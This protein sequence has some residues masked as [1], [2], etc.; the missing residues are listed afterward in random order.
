MAEKIRFF[1]LE[2]TYKIIDGKAVIHLYGK[3]IKNEQLCVLDE[4]F[5]PYFYVIPKMGKEVQEKLEKIKVE[6]ENE[7]AA[8]TKTEIAKRK[9]LGKEVDAVKVYTKLPKDVPIIREI[10]KDWN[11]LESVN[12]YDIQFRRRYLIDKG[13]TPLTLVEVEGD[14]VTQKSKVPVLKATS[15]KQ[16]SDDALENPRILAFDIE[17][18]SPLGKAIAPE[19]NPI[20]MISFYGEKFEKVFLWKKFKT[21]LKYVEFVDGEE[22]L[23]EKFKETIEHYR[24]D[25]L[26]G[27]FS[28]EFDMP[29]IKTRAERYKIKIDIGL[30]HSELKVKH[31][32]TT[33]SSITGLTHLDI[34]KFIV[35]TM[36]GSFDTEAYSLNNTAK[37]LLNEK[38]LDV[39]LDG[40]SV[41]WDKTPAQLG[42]F[43]EYNLHDSV[44]TYKLC[45]KL[46]PNIME[47]VKI[48]GLPIYD[49]NRMGFSQLVESYLLKQAYNFK[50]IAPNKP[51]HDEIRQR[52]MQT[53]KGG[54]VYEPKPGLY[55][56]IVVFDYRSLYPTIISSHNI[57]PETINCDCCREK[58]KVAPTEN[59]KEIYWFCTKKKGFIPLMIEDLI[60]RRMRIKEIIKER[61]PSPLLDARE[62]S[63][64]LLANSF[65]GYLGF[66]GARWYSIECARAT[67]AWGRFYIHNVINKA[68]GA[69]FKVLYSDTDSVFLTL[70]GKTKEAA[71]KFAEKINLELPGLMELG[72]EG[73]YTRGIFVSAKAGEFGAKKKYAL[74]TEE[75]ALKIRGFETVRRNWSFIA[76][77]VQEQV[78][79]IILK[80]NKPE[81]ALDYV[82]QIVKGLKNKKIPLE[83]VI[84]HTQLQKE[85]QDYA[86]I[87]PH[88]AIAK[89]LK[90][91]GIEVG[92]GFMI[93]YVVTKGEKKIR[94]KAKLPEEVKQE[95]YDADYYIE[96]QVIPSVEKIFAVL[97]YKKEDIFEKQGQKQL[98]KF[99]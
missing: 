35:K 85:T 68:E 49:I 90:E 82:K 26:T 73:F 63:L 93:K 62:H 45:K 78:L 66:F 75:G 54:F 48:I 46:L 99:F 57:G 79:N 25:I 52:R 8:V 38:K 71:D 29:Y 91:R 27:Y 9:Y 39:D 64:K 21:D 1:P 42:E 47:L 98:G 34:F 77:E 37:E 11:V 67:T 13:I 76:K 6:K 23:I 18:Y 44:L 51:H 65:Y 84:I 16:Y 5:E 15:I 28:D 40:M 58:A 88:V 87:G 95:D 7:E 61:K 55:S 3:T 94:D 22:E 17:T 96:N 41:I 56:D 69:G 30:D 74:L 36:G 60:K 81:K 89:K 33:V 4:N 24:P 80:E 14:F 92:P 19:K 2:V 70:D 50:E 83:K 97:G 31:G 12:E 32:R 10:I 43:C 72:Y 86:A 59:K 53:Y 20:I